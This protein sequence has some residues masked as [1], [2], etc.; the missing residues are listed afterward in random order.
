MADGAALGS[1]LAEIGGAKIVGVD[2]D[3]GRAFGAAV[4]F[5][6]ANAEMI[7]EGL[8]YALGEFFGSGHYDAEAAEGFGRAAA[9]VG[10]Q[11]GRRGKHH[12]HGIFADEGGDGLRV[13]RAGMKDGADSGHGGEA[14]SAGEA[15]GVEEGKD[16]EDG[17]AFVEVEDL[18]D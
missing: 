6:R 3:D 16:A 11:E 18:F 12:G 17:I 2:G 4:A 7:F 8:G 5:E 10:V 15:E 9:G 1:Y 14:E 13:E